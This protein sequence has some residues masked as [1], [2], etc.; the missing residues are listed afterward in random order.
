MIAQVEDIDA[1][2]KDRSWHGSTFVIF[3][4]IFKKQEL[5]YISLYLCP[6]LQISWR[7]LLST[8]YRLLLSIEAAILLVISKQKL[9]V[10][11]FPAQ[12][13]LKSLF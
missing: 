8:T 5:I 6:V 12:N 2:E 3:R 13:G 4:W 9:T 7:S 10:N 11:L 1:K